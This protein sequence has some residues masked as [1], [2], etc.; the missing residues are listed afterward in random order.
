MAD[1]AQALAQELGAPADS[2][3]RVWADAARASLESHA[4][5]ARIMI[6]WLRLEPS[7]VLAMA[8]RPQEQAPEWV[9]IEPFFVTCLLWRMFRIAASPPCANWQRCA[10]GSLRIPQR[11]AKFCSALT[12]SRWRS[13]ASARDA[14]ALTRRLVAIAHTFAKHVRRDG[15]HLSL[16]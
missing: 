14:S 1:I 10:H 15:L 8:E 4:R 12:L 13:M 2:E 7:E 5:D 11:I 16:R 9:A 3:L 6:P